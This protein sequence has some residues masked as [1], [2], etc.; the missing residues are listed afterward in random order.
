MRIPVLK[1]DQHFHI[2]A[3]HEKNTLL[4][5]KRGVQL[6]VMVQRKRVGWVSFL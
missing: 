6:Q 4:M 2:D 5:V 3:N 1:P